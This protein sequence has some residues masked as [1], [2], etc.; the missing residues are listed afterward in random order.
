MLRQRGEHP[1]VAVQ[2]GW[3]VFVARVPQQIGQ[4]P[5]IEPEVAQPAQVRSRDSRRRKQGRVDT[6]RAR[7]GQ[8]VDVDDHVEQVDEFG[9]ELEGGGRLLAESVVR[10]EGSPRSAPL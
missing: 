5:E 2:Q 9:V 6:T 10:R 1:F 7:P 3:C 8:D 4:S